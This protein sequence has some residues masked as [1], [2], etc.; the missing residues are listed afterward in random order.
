MVF[1]LVLFFVVLHKMLLVRGNHHNA[2]YTQRMKLL[3]LKNIVGLFSLT[4]SQVDA[5]GWVETVSI[6]KDDGE[7]RGLGSRV[8]TDAIALSQDLLVVSHTLLQFFFNF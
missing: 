7:G 3:A 6:G 8:Y 4:V 1:S 2:K 5:K